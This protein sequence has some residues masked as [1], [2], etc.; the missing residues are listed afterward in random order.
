MQNEVVTN[1]GYS[2]MLFGYLKKVFIPFYK[3]I[4]PAYS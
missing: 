2:F 4:I 3:Q 1:K